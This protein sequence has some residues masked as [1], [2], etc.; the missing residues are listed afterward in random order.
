MLYWIPTLSFLWRIWF[1]DVQHLGDLRHN[2]E[3]K[4]RTGNSPILQNKRRLAIQ[5]SCSLAQG[6]RAPGLSLVALS[7]AEVHKEEAG[8]VTGKAVGHVGTRGS[9]D[10][11]EYRKPPPQGL[12]PDTHALSSWQ[13][14]NGPCTGRQCLSFCSYPKD[15]LCNLSRIFALSL[16]FFIKWGVRTKGGNF[17]S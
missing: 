6:P 17:E 12:L 14:W 3:L 10:M 9:G 8:R 5:D 2:S 4:K 15:K 13:F 1:L 7:K 11:A 16:G